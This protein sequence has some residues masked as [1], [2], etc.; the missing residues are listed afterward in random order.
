[1]QAQRDLRPLLLARARVKEPDQHGSGRFRRRRR[2]ASHLEDAARSLAANFSGDP[3]R[4]D[5]RCLDVRAKRREI[6]GNNPA[7]AVDKV[8][9]SRG[10][11]MQSKI[12]HE[13]R[14]HFDP[15]VAPHQQGPRRRQLE[16]RCIRTGGGEHVLREPET[17]AGEDR[18]ADRN[19]EPKQTK[20][21]DGPHRH[22][23]TSASHRDHIGRRSRQKKGRQMLT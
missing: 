21:D 15:L 12:A 3:A 7:V 10:L 2:S 20:R 16:Q 6:I 18:K 23:L 9:D 13:L 17:T 11:R 4:R 14:I 8:R 19:A 22:R 1:M 5:A